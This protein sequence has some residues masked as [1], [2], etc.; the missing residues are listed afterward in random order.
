[1]RR[2]LDAYA[3]TGAVVRQAFLAPVA[4]A[5]VELGRIEEGLKVL[6]EAL[7]RVETTG[8]QQYKSEL[9]RLKGE[10]LLQNSAADSEAE[11]WF[12]TGVE[13]AKYQQAKS[14]EIRSNMS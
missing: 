14:L 6:N 12:R 7:E 10:L 1:M 4:R 2:G 3:A 9:C 11:R 13:V 8:D 5:L